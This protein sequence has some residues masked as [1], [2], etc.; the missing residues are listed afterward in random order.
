ML[1]VK[2]CKKK[3]NF[4]AGW[5]YFLVGKGLVLM[6]YYYSYQRSQVIGLDTRWYIIFDS[7]GKK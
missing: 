5:L 3:K 7:L 6:A 1:S 2:S 4:F